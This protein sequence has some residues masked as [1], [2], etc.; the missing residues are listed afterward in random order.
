MKL[1]GSDYDGTLNYQGIDSTKR[2][3]LAQWRA[4]GNAFAVV[5][6]RSM[7]SLLDMWQADALAYDYLIA[8]NGAVVSYID[9]TKIAE[10]RC[11]GELARPLIEA[12]FAGGCPWCDI[13]T[14][15][16]YRVFAAP[17]EPMG[18]G[19][20]T[21]DTLPPVSYFTQISTMLPDFETA[22]T[23]TDALKDAFGEQLNP[24]QNGICIDVVR[25]DVNKAVGLRTLARHLHIAESDI[26][27]VGDN[28]NDTD[29]IAAFFS[30][31]MENGV[32]SIKALA[33]RT[34]PSVTA[35]IDR[36]LQNMR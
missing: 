7:D 2:E 19:D 32:D 28:V 24:L 11:A 25:R 22:A 15:R 35:L 14:D 12:M 16:N 3:A 8:D 31:A 23:V 5:S 17:R 29:M 33:D 18:D 9:G 27:A 1:I 10:I 21:L 26:V 30:Y 20:C 34:T 13:H 6:G 4:A 36:E